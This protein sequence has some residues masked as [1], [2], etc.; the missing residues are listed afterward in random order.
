M[1]SNS[2]EIPGCVQIADPAITG[3]S[4]PEDLKSPA[5]GL[6]KELVS[7]SAATRQKMDQLFFH[8]LIFYLFVFYN[9]IFICSFFIISF[10][11]R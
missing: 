6:A 2:K 4:K 8:T 1:Y 10:C 9:L 3:I 7:A 11:I 5:S